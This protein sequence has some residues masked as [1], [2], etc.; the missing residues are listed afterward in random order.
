MPLQHRGPGERR[1]SKK[2]HNPLSGRKISRRKSPSPRA[3][4]TRAPV[5]AVGPYGVRRAFHVRSMLISRAELQLA[6]Q[7][8]NS[9]APVAFALRPLQLRR[10]LYSSLSI[11]E[12][13]SDKCTSVQFYI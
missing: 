6:P 1:A 10:A 12:S 8:S 7:P 13:Q 9:R 4:P 11:I 5:V 3:L 2:V